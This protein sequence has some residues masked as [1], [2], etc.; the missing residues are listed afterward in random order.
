LLGK[1]RIKRKVVKEGKI[2]KKERGEWKERAQS[3]RNGNMTLSSG[4]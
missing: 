4:R 3:V 1:A 2:R